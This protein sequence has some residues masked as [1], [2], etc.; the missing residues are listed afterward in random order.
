M[1]FYV[2]HLLM[3]FVCLFMYGHFPVSR[4]EFVVRQA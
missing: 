3:F 2:F 1:C 4:R